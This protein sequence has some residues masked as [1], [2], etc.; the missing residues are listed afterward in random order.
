MYFADLTS[1]TTN[2]KCALN[3]NNL[4]IIGSSSELLK[5]NFGKQIDSHI[6]VLRINKAP[7]INYEKHVG[8]KTTLMFLNSGFQ[9][10][11]SIDTYKHMSPLQAFEHI[12]KIHKEPY[13][14]YWCPSIAEYIA[15][16]HKKFPSIKIYKYESDDLYIEQKVP[17]KLTFSVRGGMRLLIKCIQFGCVPYVYGFDS[18]NNN[19]Q[20]YNEKSICPIGQANHNPLKEMILLRHLQ[21]Q[22]LIKLYKYIYI[23]DC[24]VNV[25]DTFDKIL[26][27]YQDISNKGYDY[28]ELHFHQL[29]YINKLY[30]NIKG[31]LISC[32]ID[33]TFIPIDEIQKYK[34][35]FL[36][37]YVRKKDLEKIIKDYNLLSQSF[38]RIALY[39]PINEKYSHKEIN[40]IS[41]II[42]QNN[43]KIVYV[44]EYMY[45][46]LKEINSTIIEY[47]LSFNCDNLSF[48]NYSYIN[49]DVLKNL[50]TKYINPL[51]Q[52]ISQQYK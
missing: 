10:I 20:Y 6:E 15:P 42:N 26:K 35:D 24:S 31:A 8:T 47:G 30:D 13:I 34:I 28:F 45:K 48:N 1:P 46:Q 27:I 49:T 50:N 39:F 29:I 21:R 43:I 37:L 17:I 36:K 18:F 51:L 32:L 7:I 25:D 19:C 5:R 11:S 3:D 52:D 16:I 12:L 14:L 38:Y 41:D 9:M 2:Q 23:I 40:Y 22:R 44:P 33:T 4:A